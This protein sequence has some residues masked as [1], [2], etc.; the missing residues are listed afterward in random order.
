MKGVL[1][2]SSIV[3]EGIKSGGERGYVPV[4]NENAV[5]PLPDDISRTIRGSQ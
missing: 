4:R 3:H 2:S 1:R 5:L